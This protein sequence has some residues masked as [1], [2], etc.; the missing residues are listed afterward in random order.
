MKSLL[1]KMI[2]GF[3]V[4]LLVLTGALVFDDTAQATPDRASLLA[5]VGT[6]F[7][8]QGF[9]TDNGDP[10]SGNYNLRFRLYTVQLG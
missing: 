6:A 2:G 3:A 8:Y 7:T 1:G 4:A 9:I 10:A 5:P